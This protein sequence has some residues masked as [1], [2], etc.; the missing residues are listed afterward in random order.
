MQ[1][2]LETD[3]FAAIRLNMSAA[4]M[5]CKASVLQTASSESISGRLLARIVAD[6]R[7]THASE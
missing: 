3:F 4:H 1:E 2:V 6:R 5:L 7:V